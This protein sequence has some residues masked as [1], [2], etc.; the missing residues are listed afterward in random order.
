M[1]ACCGVVISLL[2]LGL[3]VVVE[4]TTVLVLPSCV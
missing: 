3:M 1:G 4:A 2:V